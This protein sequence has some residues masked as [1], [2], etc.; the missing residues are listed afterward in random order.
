MQ[1]T[2]DSR[3]ERK[4]HSYLVYEFLK[5]HEQIR[6]EGDPECASLQEINEWLRTKSVHLRVLDSKVDFSNFEHGSVR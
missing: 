3:V 2:R 5:C 1:G 4:D 6:N